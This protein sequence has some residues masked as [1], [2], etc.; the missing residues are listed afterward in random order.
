M[1]ERKRRPLVAGFLSLFTPGLGQFYN[2]QIRKAGVLL[3]TTYILYPPL[4]FLIKFSFGALLAVIAAGFAVYG[5]AIIQSIVYSY[6]VKTVANR[7]YDR[8]YVYLAIVVSIMTM[9]QI[10]DTK[11]IV[12]LK[13]YIIAGPSMTP[14]IENNERVIVDTKSHRYKEGDVVVY[15][16]ENQ[17]RIHRIIAIEGDTVRFDDSGLLLNGKRVTETYIS[18]SDY[19]EAIEEVQIPEDSYYILGDNRGNSYDSRFIGAIPSN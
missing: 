18:E 12:G 3:L 13:G 16:S 9:S 8:W 2:G 7:F 5:Y 4:L 10:I 14:T 11:S 15:R 17:M 1:L 19:Y 6:R